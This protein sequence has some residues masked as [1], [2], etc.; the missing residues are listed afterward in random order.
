MNI[1]ESLIK[2]RVFLQKILLQT[3]QEKEINFEQILKDLKKVKKQIKEI[4]KT[5]IN[6]KQQ[7][8]EKTKTLFKDCDNLIRQI[9]IKIFQIQKKQEI[10]ER[11]LLL[12]QDYSSI[13]LRSKKDKT[14]Q[15]LNKKIT[16]ELVKTVNLMSDEVQKSA[17]ILEILDGSSQ[18]LEKTL[19]E[20]YSVS[21]FIQMGHNLLSQIKRKEKF[22]FY[23]V[24]FGSIFFLLVCLYVFVKR[25]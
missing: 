13:S 22:D 25:F 7:K 18:T 16:K 24:V 4:Q 12:E 2:N 23:L 21:D 9:G 1:E 5:I 14:D 6:D 15:E 20:N 8:T 19:T 17:H 11:E 3:E 10:K